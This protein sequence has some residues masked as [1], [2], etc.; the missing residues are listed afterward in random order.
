MV[1]LRDSLLLDNSYQATIENALAFVQKSVAYQSDP[2]GSEYPRYPIETLIEGIGD[3]E[4]SSILY[5]SIVRTF[6]Y[7]QGVLLVSLD[8]NNDQVMDHVA[9]LV[10]VADCFVNA[11]P[12]RSLWTINGHTYAFA[13]TAISGGYCALGIDPWGLEQDNICD[14]WDVDGSTQTLRAT[15]RAFP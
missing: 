9:V 12:D 2:A 8:T 1:E 14:I 7:S 15:K 11:H 13:E 3:C 10:R 5:A 6:G 4:D